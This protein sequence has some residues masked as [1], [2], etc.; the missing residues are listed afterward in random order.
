[1]IAFLAYRGRSGGWQFIFVHIDVREKRRIFRRRTTAA[2]ACFA[3]ANACLGFSSAA[4]QTVA[5]SGKCL[6]LR[7]AETRDLLDAIANKKPREIA[8]AFATLARSDRFALPV[9]PRTGRR[10]FRSAYAIRLT[11][12]QIKHRAASFINGVERQS[13][14]RSF[15]QP[16]RALRRTRISDYAGTIRALLAIAGAFP[17]LRQ[18]AHHLAREIGDAVLATSAVVGI[19]AIPIAA[20]ASSR[21]GNAFLRA[22]VHRLLKSCAALQ[23][24]LASGWLVS[25]RTPELHYGETARMGDAFVA[26]T[27]QTGE[28]RY[29]QWARDASGWI[30]R[31][32]PVADVHANAMA[33]GLDAE[34]FSVTAEI[35]YLMRAME[36]VQFG[37]LPAFVVPDA[38]SGGVPFVRRLPLDDLAEVA[39]ALVHLTTALATAPVD[40]ITPAMLERVTAA[41]RF[42][43]GMFQERA[44]ADRRLQLP[45]HLIDLAIDIERAQR[46]GARL[47][48]PD[49]EAF[50]HVLAHGADRLQRYIPMAGAASGL[51]LAKL[52]DRGWSG[53]HRT[54]QQDA[55]NAPAT[56]E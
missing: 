11:D 42:A 46:A 24:A 13:K 55:G 28:P 43:Y 19:P 48:G 15:T 7:A 39:R 17:E 12:T 54:V 8:D 47:D 9:D 26:L 23:Q 5:P 36:R 4:A 10:P 41:T 33:A 6:E 34:L 21:R 31:H 25:T 3:A 40:A 45:S 50:R 37:V 18:P 56:A 49:P 20:N 1:M 16:R 51:L 14:W 53:A 38:T 2:F 32:R 30:S 35:K 22:P 29:L 52:K 27:R 44:L